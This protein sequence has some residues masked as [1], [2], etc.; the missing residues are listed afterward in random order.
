MEYYGAL[1]L[2]GDFQISAVGCARQ[3]RRKAILFS[4]K[5]VMSLIVL[6]DLHVFLVKELSLL[7]EEGA[8]GWRNYYIQ[9]IDRHPNSSTRLVKAIF[10]SNRVVVAI[11]LCISSDNNN[12]VMVP[13]PTDRITLK[14]LISEEIRLLQG[15]LSGGLG[16]G[17]S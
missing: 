11:Q 1:S 3:I 9:R 10:D 7:P 5:A 2:R 13:M 4:E 14:A 8:G 12:A 6:D 17:K 16:R 15:R